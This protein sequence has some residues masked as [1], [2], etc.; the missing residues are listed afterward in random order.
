M[1]HDNVPLMRALFFVGLI[2]L[3]A[4]SAVRAE[5][6]PA[7]LTGQMLVADPGMTDPRFAESVVFMISH[8]EDGAIGVVVNRPMG[9]LPTQ[10]LLAGEPGDVT[11]HYGGP[12]QP[13]LIM[14]LHD[15]ALAGETSIVIDEK[16]AVT[17]NKAEVLRGQDT[18]ETTLLTLGYAGW[19]PGQLE[20]E[21]AAGFWGVAPAAND[22]LFGPDDGHKWERARA[23]IP[24]E[25]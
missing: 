9:Q 14:V 5:P 12:V 25:L 1:W 6:G 15:A 11:I 18:S 2:C 8:N 16:L 20:A 13:S 22:I 24:L 7:V 17:A 3:S 21:L 4:L 23:R 19:G 10:Q